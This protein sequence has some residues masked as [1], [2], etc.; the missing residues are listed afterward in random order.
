MTLFTTG[1]RVL[2]TS[3]LLM[4]ASQAVAQPQAPEAELK[5]AIMTNMLLFV[6]WPSQGAQTRD[7]LTVCY[8]GAGLVANALLPLRGTLLKGKPLT[9][10]HVEATDVRRCHALYVSPTE[11]AV[12]PLLA[13][14]LQGSGIL[15]VGDSP[16]YL[17]RGVMVNLEIGGGR[18]VFDI[19]L[20][21]LRESG[22][23][24]SSKVLRLAR[25]VR[26]E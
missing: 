25:Q 24:V 16:G 17:Q 23:S 2:C 7:G 22:L 5:A 11:A 1:R 19:N 26:E 3:L 6:D 10:E 8:L 21:S 9:V 4:I 18:V 14:Q 20:R 12:L 15:L 13:S